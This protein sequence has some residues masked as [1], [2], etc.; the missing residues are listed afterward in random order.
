VTI[1]QIQ[2]IEG[3]PVVLETATTGHFSMVNRYTGIVTGGEEADIVPLIGEYITEV[4]VKEGQQVREG[5]TICRLSRDNPTASYSQAKLLLENAER[6]VKRYETLFNQGA[7]ARQVLDNASLARDLAK[8]RL[9]S[10]ERVLTL[11]SPIAG[12]VTD[13]KAESGKFAAPGIALARVISTGDLRIKIDIP[14]TDRAG[15]NTGMKAFVL[16][17]GNRIEGQVKR[18]ALS[19]ERDSRTFV[20]WIEIGE[21]DKNFALSSGLMVDIELLLADVPDA[22]TVS[23]DAVIRSGSERWLY[24]I[25]NNRAIRRN[26]TVGGSSDGRSWVTSGLESNAQIVAV[27]ANA[28]QDGAKVRVIAKS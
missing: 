11:T 14:A 2:A 27:G 6:D 25:D 15:T 9:V 10:S 22:I 24:A 12:I 28:L 1:Q 5:A 19:A 17:N 8:E 18:V 21:R 4:L 3:Y 20:A 16:V 13:L 7:V 26:I 23:N